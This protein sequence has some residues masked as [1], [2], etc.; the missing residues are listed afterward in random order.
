MT[1][2]I[3]AVILA[4]VFPCAALF[5][6]CSE[7]PENYN[8][9]KDKD[10]AAGSDAGADGDGD[11]DSAGA[12][13]DGDA[14]GDGTG[15]NQDTDTNTRPDKECAV[16]SGYPC[17]CDRGVG[18]EC[19]DRSDCLVI[20]TKNGMC[21]PTCAYPDHKS[22]ADTQGFGVAANPTGKCSV[23]SSQT[24]TPDHCGVTCSST[25]DCPPR[26]VCA[27]GNGGVCFPTLN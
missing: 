9:K 15:T 2:T 27:G 24:T 6:C 4:C 17:A 23:V 5:S 12:D 8:V 22:C 3:I 7:D 16:N 19:D 18:G 26:L 20:G 25:S 21:S 11:E 10:A 14:D 13:A 1:K